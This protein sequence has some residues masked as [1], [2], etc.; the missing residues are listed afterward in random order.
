MATA[1]TIKKR[2]GKY[3]VGPYNK[4][5]VVI[6][7]VSDS[8]NQNLV[9]LLMA[10]PAYVLIRPVNYDST[11]DTAS[12]EISG[13]QVTVHDGTVGRLYLVEAIGF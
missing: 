9:N 3:S 8:D 4:E 6:E 10:N 1:A 5:D 2:Y 13:R 7:L 12:A 11:S